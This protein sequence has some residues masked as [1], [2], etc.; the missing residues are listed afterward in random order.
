MNNQNPTYLLEEN[1]LNPLEIN[2][3]KTNPHEFS[4]STL[5][6]II[7]DFLYVGV[8]PIGANSSSKP[9]SNVSSNFSSNFGHNS[10]K[11]LPEHTGSEK[12][13]QEFAE[14][15]K[16]HLKEQNNNQP[17]CVAHTAENIATL[18]STKEPEEQA[19]SSV[20]KLEPVPNS[21]HRSVERVHRTS[22]NSL[23]DQLRPIRMSNFSS[24]QLSTC[25]SHSMK[26]VERICNF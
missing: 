23:V 25:R 20:S 17:L 19:Q 21:N 16:T 4:Y 24:I 15:K 22:L 11:Q 8:A 2:F 12:C 13:E 10:Q 3:Q 26:F 5:Q 14:F 7:D 1:F 6:K 9:S 18:T